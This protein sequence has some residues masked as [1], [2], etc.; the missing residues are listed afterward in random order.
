M[1][2]QPGWVPPG[3]T[4]A[5]QHTGSLWGSCLNLTM[6]LVWG[7]CSL[8]AVPHWGLGLVHPISGA[9]PSLCHHCSIMGCHHSLGP[10]HTRISVD[11]LAGATVLSPLAD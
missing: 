5:L 7:P 6:V 9:H 11:F 3:Q 1:T 8:V 10:A 2:P 4:G